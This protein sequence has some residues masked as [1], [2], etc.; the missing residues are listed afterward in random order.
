MVK[1]Y[2]YIVY[3]E[4]VENMK[5]EEKI[6]SI[7]KLKDEINMLMHERY[8]SLAKKYGLSL[9]QF[10]LLMELDEL[11]LDIY[12]EFKAPTIGEIA[13]KINNS[14]NT[15]SERVTRLEN[16]GLVNRIKDSNDKR[17]S[18]VVLA[19]K[20]RSLLNSISQ[21]ANSQYL[22]NSISNMEDIDIDNL[23]KCLGQLI[24]KMK[25]I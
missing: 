20:G 25:I 7:I 3:L 24:V 12:D 6:Q 13:K 4:G 14:Q 23:Y 18:R 15:V 8:H 21:E 10:H 16:K 11:M 9:E 19:D 17:I 1:K 22:F 2:Y 5:K